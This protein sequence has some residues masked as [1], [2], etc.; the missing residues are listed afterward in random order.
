VRE[1]FQAHVVREDYSRQSPMTGGNRTIV[2]RDSE[3][4][5][6]LPQTW[7][8][9]G[10]QQIE[11]GPDSYECEERVF[12]TIRAAVDLAVKDAT[13]SQWLRTR[14]QVDGGPF[15]GPWMHFQSRK[16]V[17][18]FLIEYDVARAKPLAQA[19]LRTQTA[20]LKENLRSLS[21]SA[22]DS[23]IAQL[24]LIH[25]YTSILGK[26]PAP[27]VPKP[28]FPA[29]VS[30]PENAKDTRLSNPQSRTNAE[31]RKDLIALCN[32]YHASQEEF[33]TEL[34]TT[35]VPDAEKAEFQALFDW[36][37]F[38]DRQGRAKF[39]RIPKQN[40]PRV[41][42]IVKSTPGWKPSATLATALRGTVSG[43]EEA[44]KYY[45]ALPA[46]DSR[47]NPD[48]VHQG[49]IDDFKA[50]EAM[51]LEGETGGL[52]MEKKD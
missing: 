48:D 1:L 43:R 22:Y 13:S 10:Y 38:T 32:A 18:A 34:F 8:A 40:Y 28:P 6:D 20:A 3:R 2:A 51:L 15:P 26:H 16:E 31:R 49:T 41:F 47:R 33:E 44:Q 14:E 5:A 45:H 36:K 46:S 30:P 7:S 11:P 23:M 9:L 27:A 21:Q 24:A 29:T 50:G 19:E 12:L 4:L 42:K 37:A 17:E 39:N 52:D 35:P 25:N